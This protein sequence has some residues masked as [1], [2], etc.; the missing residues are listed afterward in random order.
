MTQETTN[1]FDEA[2]AE[3]FAGQMIATLNQASLALMVSIGHQTGLFDTLAGL[4]AATSAEIAR[5]AGLNERYVREWLGAVV[6]GGIVEYDAG[7][8]TYRLPAEHAAAVTR[9]AG[10]HNVASLMQFIPV[11]GN[12]EQEVINCFRGGGGVPYSCYPRFHQV[13]AET[14]GQTFDATLT[15]ST[16]PLVP[17]LIER[18]E[19]GIEV[20]DIGTGSGHAVNLMARAFP[21]SRFTG[22][23]F[24]EEGIAA[25]RAEAARWGLSNARFEVR[26]VSRL[27]EPGHYDLIT[28][29]DAI[30]DQA[31][32]AAV[33]RAIAG[34]LK[35]DG[36]FLMVDIAASSHVGENV[37]HPLGQFL[38]MISCMHCMTVSLALNGAG[39]GAVWGE[40]TA[41]R[42]LD[43]AGFPHVEVKR[44]DGD[45]LNNYYVAA[46]R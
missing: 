42:M 41:R 38:Y 5:A 45:I 16:L 2:R 25:A 40:Q 27:G 22:Y 3:A 10:P 32:P 19:A 30:H 44:V 17:G 15:G 13:M 21:E 1:T 37:G 14:S 43:E 34:A 12:V 24:S 36:V 6:A 33:L 20:A 35:D 8:E 11:V 4:A 26:D 31:D 28:A 18:L 9:A 23:D 29:F 7:R 46:K 39:L